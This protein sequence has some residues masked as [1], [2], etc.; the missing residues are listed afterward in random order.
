LQ[1]YPIVALYALLEISM[2][3][4]SSVLSLNEHLSQTLPASQNVTSSWCIVV[5]FSTSLSGY[6]LLNASE[7]AENDFYAK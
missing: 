2:A 4:I 1:P 5:L 6:T 3:V 7:T